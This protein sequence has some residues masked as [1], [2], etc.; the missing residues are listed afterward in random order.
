MTGVKIV[1]T[2][3]R[4]AGKIAATA[5]SEAI[6]ADGIHPYGMRTTDSPSEQHGRGAGIS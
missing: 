1:G 5:G 4:I 3:A 2:T 6:E